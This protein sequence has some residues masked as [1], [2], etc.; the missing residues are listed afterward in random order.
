MNGNVSEIAIS[1][2]VWLEQGT[3]L[4]FLMVNSFYGLQLIG[5]VLEMRQHTLKTREESLWRVLS[6]NVAPSISILAPRLQR[7]RHR[8][9]KRSRIAGYILPQPGDSGN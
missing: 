4:Y 8:S 3:L 6:S 9:P 1:L 2:L 5:A 7:G